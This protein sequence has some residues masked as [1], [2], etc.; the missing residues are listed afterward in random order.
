MAA[1][2]FAN[3]VRDACPACA[4]ASGRSQPDAADGRPLA[5]HSIADRRSPA[6]PFRPLHFGGRGGRVSAA[7]GI[8]RPG[9]RRP[10]DPRR[11]RIRKGK[12]RIPAPKP[13]P[14]P[15]RNRHGGAWRRPPRRTRGGSFP[16]SPR[17]AHRERPPELF[18]HAGFPDREIPSPPPPR[19]ASG[20]FREKRILPLTAA[21]GSI[22]IG[23]DRERP[24]APHACVEAGS[25]VSLAEPLQTQGARIPRMRDFP[26]G[27]PPTARPQCFRQPEKKK[28]HFAT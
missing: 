5:F 3:S 6:G 16:R 12:E 2:A 19:C 24:V 8:S 26:T 15:S 17:A 27:S 23:A 21:V 14:D 11:F 13:A 9:E 28:T 25:P 18:A 20:I 4:W 1:V 22:I 10:A 7:W